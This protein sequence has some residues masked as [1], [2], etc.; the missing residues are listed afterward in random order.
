MKGSPEIGGGGVIVGHQIEK[1]RGDACVNP[2]DDGE[3]IFH[4]ARISG[5]WRVGGINVVAQAAAPEMDDEEVAPMVVVVDA[6]V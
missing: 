2:L 6:E 1:L 4:P 3:I 5:L